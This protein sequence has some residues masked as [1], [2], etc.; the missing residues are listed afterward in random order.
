M[1]NSTLMFLKLSKCTVSSQAVAA[2]A[3]FF[4]QPDAVLKKFE[5]ENNSMADTDLSILFSAI[6]QSD[7]EAIS[8]RLSR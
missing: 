6:A 8:T 3:D 4:I 1:K 2:I 7:I 5:F